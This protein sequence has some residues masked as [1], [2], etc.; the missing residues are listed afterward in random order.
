MC[1]GYFNRKREEN[2]L[3][4]KIW[5]AIVQGWADPKK[6]PPVERMWPLDT[7]K[8]N[9]AKPISKDKYQKA[10]DAIKNFGKKK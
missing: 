8:V 7:D 2:Y 6:L 1:V 5:Y 10:L 3:H 4:R 9:T